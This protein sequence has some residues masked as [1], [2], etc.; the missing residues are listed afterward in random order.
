MMSWIWTCKNPLIIYW[1]ARL[2]WCSSLQPHMSSWRQSKDTSTR[3]VLIERTN[4]CLSLSFPSLHSSLVPRSKSRWTSHHHAHFISFKALTFL[5]RLVY[6][7][8]HSFWSQNLPPLSLWN[9]TY[10]W[11]MRTSI[12]FVTLVLLVVTLPAYSAPVMSVSSIA[13]Y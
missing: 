13:Q 1:S 11:N 3:W 6:C 9:T 10:I 2:D 4:A 12:P 7:V 5:S 8:C